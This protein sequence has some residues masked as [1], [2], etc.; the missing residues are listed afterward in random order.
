MTIDDENTN[1]SEEQ[2]TP[3]NPPVTENPVTENPVSEISN[4][5]VSGAVKHQSEINTDNGEYTQKTGAVLDI[6]E[7]DNSYSAGLYILN[8]QKFQIEGIYSRNLFN[9]NITPQDNF[10][11]SAA[12]RNQANFSTSGVSDQNRVS[13]QQNYSHKFD[14]GWKVGAYANENVKVTFSGNGVTPS[15]GYIVG[16][17]AGKGRVSGYIENQGDLKIAQQPSFGSYINMGLKVTL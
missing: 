12:Y 7:G 10:G 9:T 15:V 2:T 11:V 4:V 8:P 16:V 5:E 6:K 17:S 14:N 1:I 3:D 13:I